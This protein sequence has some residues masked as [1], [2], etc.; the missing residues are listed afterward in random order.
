M[1]EQEFRG[2]SAKKN[3]L[4]PWDG[5]ERRERLLPVPREEAVCVRLLRSKTVRPSF[6]LSEEL[7][8]FGSS[9][10]RKLTWRESRQWSNCIE[11]AK[12]KHGVS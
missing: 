9:R 3:R 10:L 4:Q 5:E 7:L 8:L 11:N 1:G 12:T 2:P 6:V